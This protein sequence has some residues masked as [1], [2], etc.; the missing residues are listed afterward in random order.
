MSGVQSIERAFA[1]LRELSL[2]P[3]G[4]TD[5]ADR[6]GLPKSTVSR[7]LAA[8]ENERAVAQRDSG[9]D[10]ELGP[11]LAAL[12]DAAGLDANMAAVVRPFLHELSEATGET[13]G[14]VVRSG[15]QVYW[16]DH[17]EVEGLAVQVQSR[18]GFYAPMHSVPAGLA[19]L[20]HL[21]ADEI[22]DYLAEPLER[23]NHHTITDPVAL[24]TRLDEIAAAGVVWS[25]G[26]LGE[27]ITAVDV[28]F[29]G[30]SGEYEG[31]LFVNAPSFRFPTPGDEDRI[32]Q[33]I[34]DAAARLS[35]RFT[36]H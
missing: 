12:A 6:T 33:L 2:G 19:L 14:F 30:A 7:L 28:P 1:V 31:A 22:D 32:E 21:P 34:V 10:Y 4:V 29:R 9:G 15:R 17:V 18:T 16:V 8:L 23:V 13:V 24:R 3:A 25:E 35:D 11:G 27:G 5:I 36:I 20:A 26:D